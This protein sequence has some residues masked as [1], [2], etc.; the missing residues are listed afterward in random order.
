[1]TNASSLVLPLK[2]FSQARIFRMG[3]AGSKAVESD[4]RNGDE[5]NAT[6]E[7]S[8]WPSVGVW[9]ARAPNILRQET[10]ST[11]AGSGSIIMASGS[12][13]LGPSAAQQ[14]DSNELA[15]MSNGGSIIVGRKEA[16]AWE[17]GSEIERPESTPETQV[18]Y[19]PLPNG[20]RLR[21]SYAA[22]CLHGRSPRPPHKP[23]QDSFVIAPA[24]GGDPTRAM[25]AVFDGHGP[26]GEDASNYCRI[27]IP[28][29]TVRSPSFGT[30][31][32]DALTSSFEAA[33]RKFL[34][35][36]SNRTGTD[37]QVS[38]STA[39]A[40]MLRGTEWMCANVGDSRVSLG[41]RLPGS[42]QV[43][44]RAISSDHKPG[45]PDE[46]ARILKA[47]ARILSEQQLGISNG[48]ADKLYVCR[49]ANG[50]IRYGAFA[51]LRPPSRACTCSRS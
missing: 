21:V 44:G 49:V 28:D 37:T 10:Y 2:P 23:N 27:N 46:R 29:L 40:V 39:V 7:L 35:N 24:L 11:F 20:T 38:G 43:T 30:A 42:A 19:I 26:K 18:F 1:M 12:R 50:A 5:F 9:R 15:S 6:G 8:A 17:P 34:A 51:A 14:A 36:A 31:P 4:A 33:H 48:D 22:T 3:C 13:K 45:R 47:G 32:F 25:F 16:G 41:S